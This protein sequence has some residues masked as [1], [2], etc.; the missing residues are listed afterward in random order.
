MGKTIVK[1]GPA[2]HGRKMSL[3]EFEHAE[4]Q[5]G[6]LYELGRGT[7]IVVDVPKGAH[8]LQVIAIRR[9]FSAYDVFH[10]GR[11]TGILGSMECKLLVGRLESERHPDVA[12]YL[13]APPDVKRKDFWSRWVPEIVIEVVS[14]SSR[15][16]DYEEKPAE[17]LGVGVQEYWI[18]DARK[19]LMVVMRRA[20]NRWVESTIRP[21]DL[22]RTRL[23]LGLEFSCEAVFRAA[24]L[25]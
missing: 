14:P 2:D 22:Y 1:I 21:P 13:S 4:V 11:I 16:R 8:A 3:E 9:Q 19:R 5:E 23:L 6:Y 15:K 25:V 17:Y 12:I 20:R 10:P 24:G 7:I 18:V